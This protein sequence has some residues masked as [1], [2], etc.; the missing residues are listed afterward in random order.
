MLGTARSVL[1]P[2][3]GPRRRREK[4]FR[5]RRRAAR[6]PISLVILA[7]LILAFSLIGP[8]QQ[9]PN[10]N[11]Q[12]V[13]VPAA[14]ATHTPL[15]RPTGLHGGHIVFTCTRGSYNQI[16]MIDA[17]GTNL[18]QLTNTSTNSYYPAISPRGDTVVFA[19]N[20]YD[21]FDLYMLDL[22]TSRLFTLTN[23][24]G[25]AFSPSF[26]PDGSQVVFVNRSASGPSAL[27]LMGRLGENPHRIFSG[28]NDIVS[29][30]WSPNGKSIAFA[31]SVTVP[32]AYEIFLM[33]SDPQNLVAHQI[34]RGLSAIGGS[35]AWSPDSS[36]LLIYAGPVGARDIYRLDVATG[37]TIQLT[38]DGSS[39][40]ACYS[41]DGQYIVYN[42]VRNNEA[43]N[44]YIMRADG[45]STHRLTSSSEP[46]WQSQW[47][48]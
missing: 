8:I 26:S 29:A 22:N 44:L 23:N 19:S 2:K 36:N 4:L 24:I 28:P 25:N 46:D 38:F 34:S 3:Y 37:N 21:N 42:S 40:A 35:L 30:A 48:F 17:D 14:A 45:H 12:N 27:W 41:P 1:H 7:V 11:P 39:A 18:R 9:F 31:M 15:P 47:G 10:I 5:E 33:G 43:A 6:I 20:K 16:C 13:T 32:Y